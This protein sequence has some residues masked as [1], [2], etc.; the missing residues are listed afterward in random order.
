MSSERINLDID[1]K[2]QPKRAN[3]FWGSD[4][5]ASVTRYSEEL[6]KTQQF[7]EQQ[8]SNIDT[9][10]IGNSEHL[11]GLRNLVKRE[12]KYCNF[13]LNL[14]QRRTEPNFNEWHFITQAEAQHFGWSKRH[15]QWQL[16][17]G[18]LNATVLID[19]TGVMIRL[20]LQVQ[21]DNEYLTFQEGGDKVLQSCH[22]KSENSFT[23]RVNE[24]KLHAEQY[25]REHM[26]PLYLAE[27]EQFE[28]L[29]QILQ[30]NQI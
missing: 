18:R 29:Q 10:K 24:Y 7:L 16:T 20:V 28:V 11:D 13:Y 8:T 17:N 2:L 9:L 14:L 21:N 30:V 4:L 6:L 23:Q 5:T 19:R 1:F 27:K 12:L 22:V 3:Q 26:F 25:L 15:E